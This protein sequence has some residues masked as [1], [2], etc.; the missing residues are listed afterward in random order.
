MQSSWEVMLRIK[1]LFIA[2]IIGG[3]L[4]GQLALLYYVF[5]DRDVKPAPS[6]N[7]LASATATSS[8]TPTVTPTDTATPTLTPSPTETATLT[9]TPTDTPT[10]SLE[11]TTPT[12]EPATQSTTI[13]PVVTEA[14]VATEVP[15]PTMTPT[16]RPS[17][18]SGGQSFPT[19]TGGN[20]LILFSSNQ[21]GDWDIY[22]T[23]LASGILRNLTNNDVD[24][25][26]GVWSPDGS[27]IA[28]MSQSDGAWD[29]W[30]MDADGDNKRNLTGAWQG[31][32][33]Q[34][35][36]SPD[37]TMLA[38]SAEEEVYIWNLATGEAI[39]ITN[40][41]DFDGFPS[42]SP[43]GTQL[44]F[45]S[46]RDGNREIYRVNA[47]GSNPIR[48]TTDAAFDDRPVWSPDGLHIV[49][50]STRGGTDP[51]LAT[52]WQIYVM[53]VTGANLNLV[54]QMEGASLTADPAFSPD[55]QWLTFFANPA[56]NDDIYIQNVITGEVVRVTQDAADER[57]PQWAP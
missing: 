20:N 8:D 42:W 5:S 6:V 40:S 9:P 37:G 28:Y 31:D 27:Q 44:V 4:L 12:V 23:S 21:D 16:Q 57:Y 51:T 7:S 50:H 11:P 22:V 41:P 17:P 36:W 10:P 19:P 46:N 34:P 1:G 43:D 39:N 25:Q 49:F 33:E 45:R 38:F 29:I 56:G 35:A 15:L 2:V 32:E 24:D 3:V 48:L 55:G 30:L 14:A 18:T 47:D 53:D 54:A 52:E 26:Q 13:E